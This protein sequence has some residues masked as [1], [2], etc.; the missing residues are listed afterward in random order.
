MSI[1]T[2]VL[3][4]VLL[5]AL[6]VAI[7]NLTVSTSSSLSHGHSTIDSYE[8][9]FIEE[10]KYELKT[11]TT[12][13]FKAVEK[14][15]LDS[16]PEN[17]GKILE[18]RGKE[19]KKNLLRIYNE[20]KGSLSKKQLQ[21]LIKDYVQTYRYDNGIGYFWINDFHPNMVM[22]PIKPSLDGK[23]L[24]GFKDRNG[25]FLFNEF[26]KT[27]KKSGSGIVS[28]AWPNPKTDKV[29]DKIS[30]VFTFEPFNWII[31]TGEYFSVLQQNMKQ[32]AAQVVQNLRYGKDGYFWINDYDSVIVM[33]PIKP[34]LD[35]QDL[36]KFKDSKGKFIFNEFVKVAKKNGAGYVDY[37]WPKPGHKDPQPKL[38]YV[39]AF[40]EWNWVVGTG[41]YVDDIEKLLEKEQ[42][43][44]DSW[45]SESITADIA[46]TLIALVVIGFLATM[47][48]TKS[49]IKPFQKIT[50]FLHDASKDPQNIDLGNELKCDAARKDEIEQIAEAVSKIFKETKITISEAKSSSNENSSVAEEL[51]ATALSIGKRVEDGA[52]VVSAT[53]QMGHDI[54]EKLTK[55]VSESKNS[56]ESI[57]NANTNLQEAAGEV[58]KL[59][60]T[61]Q[62]SAEVEMEMADRLKTLSED[63]DQVKDVLNVISDIA[64]Q[65]NLLALNAAIEAARAG[66]HGRGFAVVADEVRKLAE[67]TQ[68]S[69]SEINATVNIIV[70]NIMDSSGQMNK[71]AES[72]QE[73][74]EVSQRLRAKI[75]DS[76]DTL[77]KTETISRK[78]SETSQELAFETEK[79]LQG[80]EDVNNISAEN[81]RSVEEIAAASEHLAKLAIELNDKLEKFKTD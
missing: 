73:L 31:G 35:G 10:R 12:I 43:D 64:E 14:F 27:C 53:T 54:K 60:D 5:P 29:E 62:S 41:V 39:K 26:V 70:Q 25:K 7:I 45:L 37:Y 58:E 57:K 74:V 4:L 63:A 38:S 48:V 66:E 77:L 65:T 15:Y 2:R 23:D 6:A 42:E 3:L 68:K 11:N 13:A 67:R 20:K 44:V 59:A 24:S 9:R 50:D 56:E 52:H 30:Y 40:P 33:H 75:E 8:K 81:T 78:S 55:A 51:S 79:M 17:I 46:I 16:K 18:K 1:K 49:I 80:I 61:V 21:N 34:Q 22:H 28:Y 36:S 69:L 71:N 19:F 32:E 47:S 76:A 72:V